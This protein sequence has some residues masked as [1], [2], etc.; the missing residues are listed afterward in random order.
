MAL[1]GPQDRGKL[2][3][4]LHGGMGQGLITIDMEKG[5][6]SRTDLQNARTRRF[7]ERIRRMHLG[8]GS[9]ASR[10]DSSGNARLGQARAYEWGTR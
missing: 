6:D 1:G 4:D 7:E 9:P 8:N 3:M 5:M 10:T 2:Q